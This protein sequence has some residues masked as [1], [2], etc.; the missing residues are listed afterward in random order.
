MW[1]VCERLLVDLL[2]SDP[3]FLR[4]AGIEPCVTDGPC[5]GPPPL[6]RQRQARL[7]EKDIKWLKE[8]GVTWEQRPAVQLPL[9]FSGCRKNERDPKAPATKTQEESA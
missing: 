6:R 1:F 3:A 5:P 2:R 4:S 9:D 7:T 8:C